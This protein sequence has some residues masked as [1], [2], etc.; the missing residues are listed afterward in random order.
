MK[1]NIDVKEKWMDRFLEASI[2]LISIIIVG[3][4]TT[5]IFLI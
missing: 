5:Y 2:L 4:I 3:I 1:F